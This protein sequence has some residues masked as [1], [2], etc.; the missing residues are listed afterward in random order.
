[1]YGLYPFLLPIGALSHWIELFAWIMKKMQ[2]RAL[3]ML[4]VVWGNVCYDAFFH[5]ALEDWA[6]KQLTLVLHSA[7]F[8][9]FPSKLPSNS[10][11]KKW[12]QH[13]CTSYIVA[14]LPNHQGISNLTMN[15]HGFKSAGFKVCCSQ[16]YN[17][18]CLPYFYR[19]SEF[20]WCCVNK[21][22]DTTC[23]CLRPHNINVTLF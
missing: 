23:S 14:S 22:S 12:S 13:N 11:A 7:T 8:P 9:K 19:I 21:L 5:L 10:W 4:A 17:P 20:P 15:S 1:M 18:F 6:I 2:I 16:F 3:K